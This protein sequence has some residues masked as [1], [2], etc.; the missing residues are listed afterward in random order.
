MSADSSLWMLAG[1]AGWSILKK[2]LNNQTHFKRRTI[3][4]VAD[5]LRKPDEDQLKALLDLEE[6]SRLRLLGRRNYSPRREQRARLDKLRE[7]YYR[8]DHNGLIVY[9]WADTEWYDLNQH[10][11]EESYGPELCAKIKEL[12]SAALEFRVAIRVALA[13]I[14]LLS[15][16]HFDK[17]SFIPIP[18]VAALGR[19]GKIDLVNAYQKVKQAAVNLA[20]VYGEE[21]EFANE[22]SAAM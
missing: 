3:D 17:I 6:D 7:Q 14:W 16:I 2:L 13:K 5:L 1:A 9:Q 18:S 21:N 11:L 22:I 12:R 19:T 8:L 20:S 4:E 10:Q 15:L